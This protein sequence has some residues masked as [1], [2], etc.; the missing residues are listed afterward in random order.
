[1]NTEMPANLRGAYVPVFIGATDH[2]GAARLAVAGLRDR[3][4]EFLDIAD[5]KIDELDPIKWDSFIASAW[6]DFLDYFP[7]QEA[8]LKGLASEFYFTGP[9]ASYEAR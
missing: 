9:F 7:S 4:F 2:E 3:G 5:G 8:V 6:P 1:S